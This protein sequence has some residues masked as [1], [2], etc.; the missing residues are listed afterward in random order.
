[1]ERVQPISALDPSPCSART[2]PTPCR[3]QARLDSERRGAHISGPKR[4]RADET[5]TLTIGCQ[6]VG[7]RVGILNSLVAFFFDDLIGNSH[8]RCF[9]VPTPTP[10]PI[11]KNHP[12][13]GAS[14]TG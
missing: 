6:G 2:W 11:V 1:M 14:K 9:V 7:M 3:S 13:F 10:P 12:I 5:I 8:R 4:A